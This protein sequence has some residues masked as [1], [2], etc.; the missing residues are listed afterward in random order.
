M[1]VHTY[2]CVNTYIYACTHARTQRCR[3]NR[4]TCDREHDKSKNKQHTEPHRN[5]PQH[6]VMHCNNKRTYDRQH[7]ICKK[8]RLTETHRNTVQRTATT[9]EH[10]EAHFYH[11]REHDTCTPSI[12][13]HCNPLQPTATHCNT[14]QHTA[15]HCISLHAIHQAS[16]PH[17][18]THT[19]RAHTL[20]LTHTHITGK[21]SH[22]TA[23]M[24]PNH[25]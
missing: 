21:L 15:T 14:L 11:T 7:D 5:T 16:L 24:P 1:Y 9:K 19:P 17:I 23:H 12:K 4:R 20:S 22:T 8:K 10:T 25:I 2:A 13:H 3:A 18:S 6:A